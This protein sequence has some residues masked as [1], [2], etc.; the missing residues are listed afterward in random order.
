MFKEKNAAVKKIITRQ[1]GASPRSESRTWMWMRITYLK[2]YI[3]LLFRFLAG[4][5]FG[6]D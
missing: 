5:R 1:S 2:Q 3:R 4:C 6:S